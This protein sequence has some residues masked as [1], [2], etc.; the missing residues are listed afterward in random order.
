MT[1][2]NEP[3]CQEE[4]R[5]FSVPSW[6]GRAR[7]G[8]S[9][10][11]SAHPVEN[12]PP[13]PASVPAWAPRPNPAR[14]AI[15]QLGS[16]VEDDALDTNGGRRVGVAILAALSIAGMHS[17]INPSYFT[18]RSFAAR[19]EA[20]KQA[21]EGL[22]I[23]LGVSTVASMAMYWVFKDWVPA[24]VSEVTAIALT[25]IGLWAI[26]RP[27]TDLPAIQDQCLTPARLPEAA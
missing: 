22:L 16:G 6:P 21:I 12:R 24:V 18:L 5:M 7:A 25:G 3:K 4:R 23:G 14:Q 8:S 1:T 13:D 15:A 17:A 27:N 2:C 26:S 20:R 11:A 9:Q 19:P 10:P